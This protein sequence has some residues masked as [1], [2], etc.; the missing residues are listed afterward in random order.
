MRDNNALEDFLGEEVVD[1]EG[2]RVGTFAC[3]WE[4]EQRKAL[5]LGVDIPERSGHTHLVPAQ[6]ARLNERQAYVRVSFTW[7][8][9]INAPCLDC[10]CEMDETFEQ[11]VW[12]FYGLPVP[13]PEASDLLS[14]KIEAIRQQ[15]RRI[16]RR[17]TPPPCAPSPT[18]GTMPAEMDNPPRGQDSP[19][20]PGAPQPGEGSPCETQKNKTQEPSPE[21]SL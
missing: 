2:N 18:A 4:R 17:D 12:A 11:R 15:L 3:Y 6:G 16:D 20:A 5:L 14:Q 10:G 13:R 9:I 1:L 19:P 8:K 21:G 7:E